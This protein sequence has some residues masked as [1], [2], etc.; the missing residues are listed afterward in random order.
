L[1]SIGVNVLLALA[2]RG[3][4]VMG[5]RTMSTESPRL[6]VNVR[7]LLMMIQKAIYLSTQWAVF[8]PNDWPTR[9]KIRLSIISF[10]A[11]LWQGGALAGATADEAFTVRCDETNNPPDARANGRLLADVGV[12][13]SVPFEFVVLRVGRQANEFEIQELHRM[14]GL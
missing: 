2:G 3:V 9:A 6:Y 10:L 8:E 14:G 7:R 12:A 11:E 1:N 4:R 5:A 13:P